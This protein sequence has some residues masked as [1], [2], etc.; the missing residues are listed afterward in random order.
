[1]KKCRPICLRLVF[2]LVFKWIMLVDELSKSMHSRKQ[3]D[4]ILIDFSKAFDKAAHEKLLLTLHLYA[5][6]GD[7][8][9]WIKKFKQKKTVHCYQKKHTSTLA[10]FQSPLVSCRA[11]FSDPFYFLKYINDLH[12]HVQ[13]RVRL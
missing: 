7:T 3:T 2:K 1:M 4:L 9:K 5:I 13:S 6:R 8:L 12:E 11:L 10:L